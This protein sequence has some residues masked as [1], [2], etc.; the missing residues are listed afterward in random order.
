MYSKNRFFLLYL[1]VPVIAFSSEPSAFG[2]GDLSSSEPYGLTSNEKVILET[3]KTLKKVAQKSNYQENQLDSLRER[4][5]GLQGVIENLSRKSHNNKIALQQI[6]KHNQIDMENST[7][8]EK[9]LSLEIQEN[10][11]KLENIEGI[12]SELSKMVDDINIHYVTKVEYNTLVSDINDFKTLMAKELKE[13]SG[14]KG[15]SKLSSS[16]LFKEAKIY[17][18]KKYYTKAIKDYEELIKRNYKPAY[19]HYM[20]GEMYYKRKNYA[21]A[22]SYF[23]KSSQ[24]YTKASYMPTLMLHT[25]ISM[26]R[27]G[28]ISHAM[29]FYNA[30]VQKFPN[31]S[32][33]KE[34]KKHLD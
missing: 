16:K 20:I 10:S 12:V 31:S 7:E 32:E 30:I 15:S 25:A 24:L 1:L 22:I 9:R 28:D 2:A 17:Y 11:A 34:S 4:I 13:L 26:E 33:A 5:D 23:K 3:K 18:N 19:S 21:K 8:Y 29:V 27:T 14:S 6:K